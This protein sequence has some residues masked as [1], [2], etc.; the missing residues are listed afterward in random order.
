VVEARGE[1]PKPLINVTR[2]TFIRKKIRMQKSTGEEDSKQQVVGSCHLT[3]RAP[4]QSG[5]I[6]ITLYFITSPG[7]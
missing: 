7:D 6:V 3:R 2:F 1:G 5:N 4:S